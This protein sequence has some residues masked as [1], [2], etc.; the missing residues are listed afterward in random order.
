MRDS[1]NKD[2]F[3]KQAADNIDEIQKAVNLLVKRLREWYE[4]YLPEFSRSTESHEKF[5]DI[6][7]K[8]DKEKLLNEI[9]IEKD[10]SMGA[11]MEYKDL[12][13]IMNLAESAKTL[14]QLRDTHE[15]YLDAMMK[16]YCQNVHAIAGTL[17]TAKLISHAGGLMSL[18]KMPASTVQL[19]GA[20]KAL[21]RHLKTGAR[22]PK[23]GIIFQHPLIAKAKKEDRGRAARVLAD[24]ISI[25][26]RVDAFKGKFIGDKLKNE[27]EEMFK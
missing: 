22:P 12:K 5:V 7:L 8:R 24:K 23:Y 21:F 25:A 15:Q 17:I 13:P 11:D 6:I 14:Y 3:I 4:L 19:L 10:Y 9:G 27:L 18:A 2:N 26:A 20:E 16:E 1:V